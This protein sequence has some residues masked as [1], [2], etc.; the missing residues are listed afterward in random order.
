MRKAIKRTL[1]TLI[2]LALF[3]VW[4]PSLPLPGRGET[5]LVLLWCLALTVVPAGLVWV[6]AGRSRWLEIVGWVL[7]AGTVVLVFVR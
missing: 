2:A 4:Y 6:G 7:Q 5:V 1:T 3:G